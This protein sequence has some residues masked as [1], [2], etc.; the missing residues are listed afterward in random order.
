MKRL[1]YVLVAVI[2]VVSS[3]AFTASAADSLDLTT[4][5]PTAWVHFHSNLKDGKVTQLDAGANYAIGINAD[6]DK[7]GIDKMALKVDGKSVEY[8]KFVQLHTCNQQTVGDK[9]SGSVTWDISSYNYNK[10]SVVAGLTTTLGSSE[11][12]QY[13]NVYIDNQLVYDGSKHQYTRSGGAVQIEV[14]V[15]AGSKTLKL[16]AITPGRFEDQACVWAEPTLYNAKEERTLTVT[17]VTEKGVT[18]KYTGAKNGDNNWVAIY[19][20]GAKVGTGEGTEP[21]LYYVYLADGS[22]EYTLDVDKCVRFNGNNDDY[23]PGTMMSNVD[24]K[25]DGTRSL[26]A[27]AGKYKLVWLGGASWYDIYYET[28]IEVGK[29]PATS[30][31]VLA[32]A[33]VAVAAAGAVA[34]AKKKH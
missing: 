14:D 25:E 12:P 33:L 31:G 34:L 1:L 32:V 28:P 27:G 15:P 5:A 13:T 21:S 26:E 19:N 7:K 6:A 10:F 8:T 18:F 17:K 16:E 23:K 22:G 30:D 29:T 9:P 20:A 11:Q 24:A 4:V 2:M 3:F